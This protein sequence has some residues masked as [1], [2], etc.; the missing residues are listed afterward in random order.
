MNYLNN[1]RRLNIKF[2]I[3]HNT[4][5]LKEIHYFFDQINYLNNARKLNI[6]FEIHHNINNLKEKHYFLTYWIKTNG[7][8]LQCSCLENPRDGGA[9]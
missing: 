2:V 1:A 7:N 5:N 6:K 8:P 4:N 9:W 3:H